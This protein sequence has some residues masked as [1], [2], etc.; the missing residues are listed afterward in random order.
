[1]RW[2]DLAPSKTSG[3]IRSFEDTPILLTCTCYLA[4]SLPLAAI[5]AVF[6]LSGP[7]WYLISPNPE[8]RLSN[9]VRSL[10][11]KDH[12]LHLDEIMQSVSVRNQKLFWNWIK[13]F[14]RIEPIPDWVCEFAGVERWNG[15]V[16]WTTGV[17]HWTGVLVAISDL[18]IFTS[19]LRTKVSYH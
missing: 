1:M 6:L 5:S 14:N 15:T 16:E 17:E 3:H 4:D 18:V 8:P 9:Y 11:W 7:F 10:T 2:R 12:K 19:L 13:G